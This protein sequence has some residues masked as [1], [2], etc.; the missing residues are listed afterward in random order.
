MELL[1]SKEKVGRRIRSKMATNYLGRSLA[2]SHLSKLKYFILV[3]T[4]KPE[5]KKNLSKFSR[6]MVFTGF[7]ISMLQD[8][9]QS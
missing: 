3:R 5:R 9:E 7:I 6:F 1:Y 4:F 2:I 8:F